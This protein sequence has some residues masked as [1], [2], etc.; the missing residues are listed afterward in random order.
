[1]E[2]NKGPLEK[3]HPTNLPRLLDLMTD[4]KIPVK[5]VDKTVNLVL[6]PMVFRGPKSGKLHSQNHACAHGA[7]FLGHL[8]VK[9]INSV[10]VNAV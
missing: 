9:V 4:R 8:T 1:M 2:S 10:A 7:A 3:Q 6:W 5:N